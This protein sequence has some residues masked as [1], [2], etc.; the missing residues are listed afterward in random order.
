MANPVNGRRRT[1]SDSSAMPS[2]E[3][4]RSDSTIDT[5]VDD[6]RNSNIKGKVVVKEVTLIQKNGTSI[7]LNKVYSSI[8]FFED[9]YSTNIS[10][11]VVIEDYV[12]GL[13]KFYIS[14]GEK[15]KI[16]VA[17]AGSGDIII[18]RSNL[19]VYR[20]KGGEVTDTLNT[21]YTLQFVSDYYVKST[22][23]KIFK[24]YHNKTV[25]EIA[26][27]LFSEMSTSP[28]FVE[29]SLSIALDKPFVCTGNSPIDCMKRLAER[30]ASFGKYYTL[31]ER[32]SPTVRNTASG[33]IVSETSMFCSLESLKKTGNDAYK[34]V[35]S[36]RNASSSSVT[37]NLPDGVIRAS[38]L[39]R[40]DNFNHLDYMMSGLYNSRITT[41]NHISRNYFVKNISHVSDTMHETIL[42]E[43]DFYTNKIIDTNSNNPFSQYNGINEYP[44]EKF[45]AI[46][47]N[48][49]VP[50]EKW[51][52]KNA[53][54]YMLSSLYKL[55]IVIDGSTNKLSCGDSVS[56][57][58]PSKFRKSTTD[59]TGRVLEDEMM[60]GYYLATSVK[61]TIVNNG[62]YSK[63]VELGRGSLPV[64]LDEKFSLNNG[65]TPLRQSTFSSDVPP[66]SFN[67]VS[68]KTLPGTVNTRTNTYD[69][70]PVFGSESIPPSAGNQ[71]S[72]TVTQ[73]QEIAQNKQTDTTETRNRTYSSL[74]YRGNRDSSG[75]WNLE[76][77]SEL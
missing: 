48:D 7:S 17:K 40:L 61:H 70:L 19:V 64:N 10:G 41:L 58:V 8:V 54:G 24:S 39:V 12:G 30:V 37:E 76:N 28:L 25:K 31:F 47:V 15:L 50:K 29:S 67:E 55:Q 77:I 73:Q 11:Q 57:N 63:R 4:I 74:Q 33:G 16:V 62:V 75:W 20:V 32:L 34:V 43:K 53:L 14:G 68:V 13:E 5:D 52:Q 36:L 27:S 26:T 6:I 21:R 56:L 65:T 42:P 49:I 60:S 72:K 44:G 51:I 46:T 59:N 69:G 45:V 1:Q 18:D 35:F 22:K 2:G 23:K 9:I 71:S 3:N 38:Q 66:S